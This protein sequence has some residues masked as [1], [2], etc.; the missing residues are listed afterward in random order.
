MVSAV[1]TWSLVSYMQSQRQDVDGVVLNHGMRTL[2]TVAGSLPLVVVARLDGLV[3]RKLT[4]SSCARWCNVQADTVRDPKHF[5][6][7]SEQ[8]TSRTS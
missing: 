5:E 7:H 8:E 2:V 3:Q 6:G 4:P 1:L